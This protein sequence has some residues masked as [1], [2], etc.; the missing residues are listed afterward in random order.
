MLAGALICLV[1][2]MLDDAAGHALPGPGQAGRP[3]HW[4]PAW[5]RP[6]ACARRSCPTSGLN[7][8]VTVLWLVGITN[9]FNLLDNMDGLAA[10]V[11]F[12]ASLVFLL[13]AWLLGELSSS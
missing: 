13:N 12:V 10:G 4:P 11:G 9:A 2:G 6:A 5:S 7:V 1:V 8:V 3:V